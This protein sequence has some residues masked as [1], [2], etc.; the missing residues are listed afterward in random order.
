M[1]EIRDWEL[2]LVAQG[3]SR[4]TVQEY[5]SQLCRLA[6]WGANQHP[7]LLA[8]AAYKSRDLTRYLA[9]RRLMDGVGP[10]S[11]GL[12]ISAARGFFGWVVGKSRSP[13]R[14]LDYPKAE[15]HEQR[16]LTPAQ[17][18]RLLE[19]PDTSSAI[20]RR[21]LAIVCLLLDTGLRA[22]EVCNLTLDGVHVAENW[23]AVP[24]KRRK[25]LYKCFS[26]A[27]AMQLANWLAVRRAADGC[28]RLF[29]SIRRGRGSQA[30][31]GK[32]ITREA[33]RGVCERLAGPAQIAELSPHDFR[34]T[35]TCFALML[36]CPDRL[37]EM[38]LGWGEAPR[39][40]LTRYSLALRVQ[41]FKPYCPV[42]WL[43]GGAKAVG[44]SLP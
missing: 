32:P 19:L 22:T 23:L 26:D 37:A 9:E 39:D 30:P 12:A 3:K 42:A 15:L 31:A 43:M 41:Q 1:Q 7:P 17:A 25:L 11:I 20:G 6:A 10:P 33:L 29:V 18:M 5:V 36:G 16:T 40:M 14:R 44:A 35:C 8:P 4:R 13:A 21:D 38:Q 24:G 28:D 2:K 34:R 27:T